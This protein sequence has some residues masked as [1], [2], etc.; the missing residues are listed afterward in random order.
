MMN[1]VAKATI[2]SLDQAEAVFGL[3]W[4]DVAGVVSAWQRKSSVTRNNRYRSYAYSLQSFELIT[5]KECSICWYFYSYKCHTD[6]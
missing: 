4:V 2:D 3:G 1:I 6:G 5:R